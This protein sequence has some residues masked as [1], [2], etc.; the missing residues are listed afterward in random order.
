MNMDEQDKQD[1][2]VIGEL[3]ADPFVEENVIVE[4]KLSRQLL[5]N[6]KSK[7]STT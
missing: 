1:W 4:L 7:S 5:R 3:Y 2:D 6:T